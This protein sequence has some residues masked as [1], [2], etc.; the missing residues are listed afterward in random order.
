MRLRHTGTAALALTALAACSSDVDGAKP[1]AQR[2]ASAATDAAATAPASAPDAGAAD[3]STAAV[4]P[5]PP[6]CDAVAPTV[7][8]DPKPHYPDVQPIFARRCVSCHN[9][10]GGQWSLGEYQHVA[11]W[12]NEIRAQML[13]CTMPPVDS[14]LTMT[15]DE[16]Q[17]ILAWIRCDYPK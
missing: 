12:F 4:P 3:G 10:S 11:D 7:C 13:G 2:D 14:G 9:G 16:R 8:P 6:P 17:T 1:A 15:L 5:A